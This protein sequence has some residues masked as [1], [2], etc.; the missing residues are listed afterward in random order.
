MKLILVD[1]NPAVTSALTKAFEGAPGEVRI[2]NDL[3]ENLPEYDCVV[4]AANSFG[5]MDGGVDKAIRDHFPG[6]EQTVQK[7][8]IER[9]SGYLPVGRSLI[10]ETN[11]SQHPF[12]AV[13]PTMPLPQDIRGTDNV[14][15]SFW[16]L[17]NAIKE[18]NSYGNKQITT[19]ACPGLGTLAGRMS[20]QGSAT[21]MALAWRHYHEVPGSLT[22]EFAQNRIAAITRAVKSETAPTPA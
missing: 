1:L 8:I 10:V 15:K 2:I 4:S 5:L 19:V 22:P 11:D 21:Q 17:L 18:F 16:A 9:S 12:V 14:Y 3:F 20:P 6:V 13:T 7:T